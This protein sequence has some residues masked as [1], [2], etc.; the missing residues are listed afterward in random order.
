MY[1][2][3]AVRIAQPDQAGTGQEVPDLLDGTV[4]DRSGDQARKERHLD[5]A[6]RT[7]A[8]LDMADL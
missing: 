5:Q 3:A 6:G 4:A 1:L 8:Q 2:L 7:S